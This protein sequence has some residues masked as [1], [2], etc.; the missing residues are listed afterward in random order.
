MIFQEL[1]AELRALCSIR[2]DCV[3]PWVL[4]PDLLVLTI[5]DYAHPV[6]FLSCGVSILGYPQVL[7]NV[8]LEERKI[9][10]GETDYF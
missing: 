1:Q 6:A 4:P 10:Q 7:T 9:S 5:T 8:V 3:A 2:G